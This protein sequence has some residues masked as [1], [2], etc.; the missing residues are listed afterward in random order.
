MHQLQLQL[1]DKVY[2][3]AKRKAADAGFATIESYLTTL[4]AD[5][6]QTEDLNHLFTPER[7]AIIDKAIAQIDAGQYKTMEQVEEH[8]KRRFEG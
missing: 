3:R 4:I 1:T 2:R 7:M 6:D 8:F 5:D